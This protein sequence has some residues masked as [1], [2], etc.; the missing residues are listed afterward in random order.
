MPYSVRVREIRG[1]EVELAVTP[2]QPDCEGFALDRG[3]AAALLL[4]AAHAL[5]Y[6][7]ARDRHDR[8]ATGALGR[9]LPPEAFDAL[10]TGGGAPE[11][12]IHSVAITA[13]APWPWHYD[14]PAPTAIYRIEVTDARWLEH[15]AAGREFVSYAWSERGPFYV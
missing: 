8:V 11:R 5:V 15:L 14:A 1:R 4:A 2:E 3:F 9:E 7:Q 12:F 6:D 10:A 13:V